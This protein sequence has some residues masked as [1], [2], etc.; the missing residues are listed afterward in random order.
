MG[1]YPPILKMEDIKR[2]NKLLK[3]RFGTSITGEPIARIV[4]SDSAFEIRRGDF[5][6]YTK[7]GIYLGTEYNVVSRQPKYS[8][9]RERWIL[10]IFRPDQQVGNPEIVESDGYEILYVFHKKNKITGIF[11]YQKPEW[12]AIEY[13]M[14]R[15]LDAISTHRQ[16]RT[17]SMDRRVEAENQLKEE[18]EVLDYLEQEENT[19]WQNKFRFREAVLIHKES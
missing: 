17:E 10:E 6:T 13:L 11:E 2:F 1:N 7:G 15:Y 4:W 14:K 18:L 8:Y 9:I 16:I 12:F 5:S 19:D 3:E